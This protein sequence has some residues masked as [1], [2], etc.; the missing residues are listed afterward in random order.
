MSGAGHWHR[1]LRHA[2]RWLGYG[3]AVLIVLLATLVGIASQL[4]PLVQRD[5][6]WIA[7]WLT[8]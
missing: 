4:L 5:P 3:L 6:Q 8:Q 2:R 1:R 7:V